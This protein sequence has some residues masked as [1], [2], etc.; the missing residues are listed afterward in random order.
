MN[1]KA[2]QLVLPA[3]LVVTTFAVAAACN[4][5]EEYC[6]DIEKKSVCD[7]EPDC[8]WNDQYSECMN[9]CNEITDQAQCEELDRCEWG[10][11]IDG[12]GDTDGV[13]FTCHAPFT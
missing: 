10:P 7:A 2:L 11:P 5:V 4:R 3:T 12:G 6:V 13:E 9:I 1:P 8:R